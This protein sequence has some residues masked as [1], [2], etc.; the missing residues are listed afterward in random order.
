MMP[1]KQ[2]WDFLVDEDATDEGLVYR[3]V[4]VQR[5]SKLDDAA[6]ES[7]ESLAIINTSQGCVSFP[8]NR[9]KEFKKW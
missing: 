3:M 1:K 7:G 2:V 5:L 6:L 4:F 9:Q 8:S